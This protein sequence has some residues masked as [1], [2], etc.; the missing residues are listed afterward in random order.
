MILS[1]R[2]LIVGAGA[3]LAG[4]DRVIEHPAARAI[5]FKGEDMHRGLQRAQLRRI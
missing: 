2:S 1:R 3:V 5:L 4:C